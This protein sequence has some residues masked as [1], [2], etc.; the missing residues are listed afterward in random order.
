MKLARKITLILP[1]F[2]FISILSLTSIQNV[3]DAPIIFISNSLDSPLNPH[4]SLQASE[5]VLN[6]T[7]Y[8]WNGTFVDNM[9]TNTIWSGQENYTLHSSSFYL[10]NEDFNGSA[11]QRDVSDQNRL[12]TNSNNPQLANNTHEIFWIFTNVTLGDIVLVGQYH[13]LGTSVDYSLNVTSQE[14]ISLWGKNYTC[15]KLVDPSNPI[16]LAYYDCNTGF[17]I[18][19]TFQY[20]ILSIVTY[21]IFMVATNAKALG[22][23][24][25]PTGSQSP[26]TNVSNPQN[27]DENSF[28]WVNGTASDDTGVRLVF[29]QQTNHT[30][31]PWSA[32]IGTNES[33]TFNNVSTI[34]DGTWE[35]QVN[36]TDFANNSAIVYCY[37]LVDTI[38]PSGFQ[39]INTSSPVIQKEAYIWINGSYSDSIPS[40]GIEQITILQSNTTNGSA[41]WSANVGG[42][43]YFAFYN[44]TPLPD[45][46]L[47]GCYE[48]NISIMDRA[49]NYLNLT[50]RVTVEINLPSGSQ[51][52]VT[53]TSNPQNAPIIWVNGTAFDN[54]FGLK[55]VTIQSSNHTGW[56]SNQGTLTAWDFYNTT[57][58]TLDGIYE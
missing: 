31:M 56:S 12:I 44:T 38:A 18:N 4:P 53:N 48:V 34:A 28:I 14:Q 5:S 29:I 54:G 21:T 3:H 45:N 30:G 27:G 40:A 25:P 20:S 8:F 37:I 19:G 32:N 2:F 33:W 42:S 46:Q 23:V 43:G 6:Q 50:C 10:V 55:N 7:Y 17:L 15:W 1:I 36:I 22:D 11:Y 13:I 57:P 26:S 51:D 39:W 41:D 9:G 24:L 49:G 52:P 58:F 16:N 47:A 35:I